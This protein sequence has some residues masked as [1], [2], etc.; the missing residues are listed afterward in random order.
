MTI[1]EVVDT[2]DAM[3]LSEFEVTVEV[4]PD[5]GGRYLIEVV[6]RDHRGDCVDW[7]DCGGGF[8]TD[9]VQHL[10]QATTAET[11]ILW[12]IGSTC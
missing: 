10:L 3:D 8:T 9:E 12:T 6:S 1:E 2:A 11:E 4:E 5:A 7:R